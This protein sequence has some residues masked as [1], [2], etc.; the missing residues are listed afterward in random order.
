MMD[1]VS[2][3]SFLKTTGPAGLLAGLPGAA[4]GFQAATPVTRE[5]T[6][7][8]GPQTK[9]KYSIKFAVIGLDHNHIIG[10]TDAVRRGGGE[11]A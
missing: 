9:P 7:A 11:L 6:A 1:D 3:R 5:V 8:P 4:L 2:R 10:I